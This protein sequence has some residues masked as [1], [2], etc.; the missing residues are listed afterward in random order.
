M[1]PYSAE[2]RSLVLSHLKMWLDRKDFR[3]ELLNI[4]FFFHACIKLNNVSKTIRLNL[5]EVFVVVFKSCSHMLILVGK[6]DIYKNAEGGL[7]YGIANLT[8]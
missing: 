1:L 4:I 2:L 5:Q 8:C 3:A 6:I 7:D